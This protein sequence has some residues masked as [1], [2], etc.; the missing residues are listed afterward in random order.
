M[1]KILFALVIS[2]VATA[3]AQNLDLKDYWDYDTGFKGVAA[4]V[5]VGKFN[6][7][8]FERKLDSFKEKIPDSA[9]S[10]SKI[11]KNNRWLCKQALNEWEYEKDECYLVLCARVVLHRIVYY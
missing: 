11:T 4:A 10:I 5:F 7:D 3:F 6:D 9:N 8:G 2:F 1:K